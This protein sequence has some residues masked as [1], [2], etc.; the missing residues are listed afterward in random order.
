MTTYVGR[1]IKA[2]YV[3][4]DPS[5]SDQETYPLRTDSQGR[6][7]TTATGGSSDTLLG[8]L[9]ETAPSTDTASSGLNGRLQR[10]AQRLTS[11]LTALAATPQAVAATNRSTTIATG[12]TAQALAGGTP[13]NGW[14]VSNPDAL[15]ESLWV[16]D[17]G[18]A[19]ANA[20]GSIEIV[21]GFSYETPP[22]RRPAGA[23]SVVAA[24]TG[25]KFTASTW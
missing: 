13:V 8:A 2:L 24:T 14:S 19:A 1:L 15:A 20:A 5:L 9:T 12:G 11:A 16:S 25:H 22:G 10:I 3:T 6:L 4:S 7:M 23:V 17:T 21:P 18:T